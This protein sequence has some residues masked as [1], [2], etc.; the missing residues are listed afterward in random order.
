[1]RCPLTSSELRVEWGSNLGVEQSSEMGAEWSSDLETEQSSEMQ[2]CE[3]G[4]P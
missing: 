3:M 4:V 1:M 2:K